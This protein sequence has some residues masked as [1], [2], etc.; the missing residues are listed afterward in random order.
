MSL[1]WMPPP[2]PLG[3]TPAGA[4]GTCAR[5]HHGWAIAPF[6]PLSDATLTL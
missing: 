6:Q 2:L 1:W 3:V 5:E 4:S